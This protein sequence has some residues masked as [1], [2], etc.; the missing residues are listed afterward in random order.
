MYGKISRQGDEKMNLEFDIKLQ[1][2]DLFRFNMYHSYHKVGTWMFTF[3]GLAILVISFTT[4]DEITANYTML[5]WACG[6]LLI[7][8]TPV[9]L[10]TTAKLRMRQNS[11]L[12]RTL[13]YNFSERGI[14]VSYAETEGDRKTNAVAISADDKVMLGKLRDSLEAFPKDIP[15]VAILIGGRSLDISEYEDMF[16]G[17][18]MAWLPGTEGAGI[19][20]VLFGEYDF[21]G[22]LNFTWY[23]VAGD[24]TSPVLYEKG[25]GLT[26]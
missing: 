3:I 24:P 13:R 8:Y 9:N 11:S 2:S 1:E 23:E 18:I 22:K 19:A 21:T 15:V 6:L 7:F 10:K 14:C 20:D 26:K 25:Y 16:D 17:I 4:M 12:A 5:Y